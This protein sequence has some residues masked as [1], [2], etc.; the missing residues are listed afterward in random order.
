M[1]SNY[2]A[3]YKSAVQFSILVGQKLIVKFSRIAA[4]TM[5][6]Q[7]KSQV[8]NNALRLMRDCFY[9]NRSFTIV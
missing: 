7:G 5:V 1:K 3:F 6:L 2:D 4:L 8:Y 9:S